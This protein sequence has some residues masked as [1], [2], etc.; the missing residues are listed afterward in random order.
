MENGWRCVIVYEGTGGVC[1]LASSR[2]A[3]RI[4]VYRS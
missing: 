1:L 4:P 2:S 3:Y